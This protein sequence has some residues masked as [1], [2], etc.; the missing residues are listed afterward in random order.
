MQEFIPILYE[1]IPHLHEF[2]H[3]WMN[4]DWDRYSLLFIIKVLQEITQAVFN[5][6]L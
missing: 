1:F 6:D 3:W 4:S 5:D 2:I